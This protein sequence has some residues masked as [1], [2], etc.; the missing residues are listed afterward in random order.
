M[1]GFCF[2]RQMSIQEFWKAELSLSSATFMFWQLTSLPPTFLQFDCR[3]WPKVIRKFSKAARKLSNFIK[4]FI[5]WQPP[6]D[7]H[8]NGFPQYTKIRN[9]KYFYYYLTTF[10][11]LGLFRTEKSCSWR[12]K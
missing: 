7:I 11:I 6:G 9:V 10:L 1:E 4:N 5:K 8:C 3:S 2:K 12:P